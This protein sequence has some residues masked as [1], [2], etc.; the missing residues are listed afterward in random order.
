M[1]NVEAKQIHQAIVN[2][3][4]LHPYMEAGNE[5]LLKTVLHPFWYYDY[6]EIQIHGLR[7]FLKKKTL[8]N[9]FRSL[10]TVVSMI[11]H[12]E[13][14]ILFLNPDVLEVL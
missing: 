10:L 4:V 14:A 8:E 7:R 9:I 11:I 3:I 2:E 6:K 1:S 13:E 5:E 12:N